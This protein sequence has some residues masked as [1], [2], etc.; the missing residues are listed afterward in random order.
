MVP[1]EEF[2]ASFQFLQECATYFLEVK[3]KDVKHAMAGLLVE[4]LMPVAACVKNEVNVPVVKNFVEMLYPTTLDMCAKKK[5]VLVC[6]LWCVTLRRG[7]RD[8]AWL[9]IRLLFIHPCI[10]TTKDAAIKAICTGVWVLNGHCIQRR[11]GSAIT[12]VLINGSVLF[13]FF[14]RPCFPW[15]PVY[16]VCRTSSFSSPTGT[17]FWPCVC[18]IWRTA[19]RKCR[20]SPWNR[21][22]GCSGTTNARENIDIEN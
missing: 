13:S 10:H 20:E 9:T 8:H 17:T 19:T 12:R 1:I 6:L 14:S 22:T 21:C 2:E 7:R 5:H 4:I 15:W 3:D 16:S 11:R 18:R